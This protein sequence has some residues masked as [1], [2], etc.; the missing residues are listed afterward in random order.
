MGQ[1]CSTPAEAGRGQKISYDD[2]AE[3]D[4]LLLLQGVGARIG[5][6]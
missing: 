4:A 2:Y 6:S 3:P 1:N 5:E